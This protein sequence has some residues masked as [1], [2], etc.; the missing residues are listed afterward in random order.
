M[1]IIID[2][3]IFLWALSDPNKISGAKRSALEDLS[4]TIYVSAVSIAELMI[5]TSVKKLRID[6][7]PV[8]MAKESG[9]TLLDFS[10]KAALLLKDMPF[11]HK[12]PF[13]R[14]LIA[15]SITDN[16]PIM[17]EDPKIALYNCQVL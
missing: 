7:D 13:D 2:T 15:Q 12:D 1:N 5:K 10:A 6:F 16:Y 3:H 11:H 17:T 9:F 8:V 14:M 4:N